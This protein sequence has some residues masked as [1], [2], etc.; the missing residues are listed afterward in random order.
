MSNKISILIISNKFDFTTDYICA[1]LN[2]RGEK[3]I[4]LNRDEFW[5]YDI[6]LE[7][8][9]FAL[10]IEIEGQKYYINES[11]KSVYYRAP[12]FLRDVF[13]VI[14]EKEQLYRS[15]W[16]SF[17]RNLAIYENALWINNPVFTYKAENKIL[18]LKYAKCVGFNIP[19]TII[20]NSN[21]QSL[22]KNKNYVVKSI[23]PAVL[24]IN[25]INAFTYTNVVRGA[26]I[27]NSDLAISPI[28]IQEYLNPKIDIRVS[29][30][31]NF[32]FAVKILKSGRG[33]DGDW[34][35]YKTELDF[36]PFELPE[37]IS[38]KCIQIVN[39]LGLIFGAIDL[40]LFNGKY[41]FIEINP[42]GE[43]AWLT[44]CFENKIQKKICDYL[45][46]K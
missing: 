32:I 14:D 39:K 9:R 45:Q 23:E 35:K 26:D 44:K 27:Y 20:T 38:Q 41:Y 42:T 33:V 36:I 25:Q 30:I 18:Q 24:K 34:R 1:E 8:A 37:N 3:Y 2:A 19:E 31:G 43:W 13:E 11:L 10:R 21:D 29:V 6:T 28:I 12:T 15:Q 17:I 4:R 7:V 22:D 46:D 16:A 5:N 40:I